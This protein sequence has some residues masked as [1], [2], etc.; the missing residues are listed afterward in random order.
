VADFTISVQLVGDVLPEAYD[1]LDA[2]MASKEFY[3]TIE[4]DDG[5]MGLPFA[6]YFGGSTLDSVTLRDL[7]AAQVR[8]DIQPEVVVFVAETVTSAIWGLPV[9][10]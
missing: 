7:I 4:T 6:T 9:E 8:A 1:D 10:D 3:A 2:L 5:V